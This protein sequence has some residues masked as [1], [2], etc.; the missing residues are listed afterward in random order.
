MAEIDELKERT[1]AS[2]AKFKERANELREDLSDAR[3][4]TKVQMKAMIQRLDE[5]YERATDRFKDL[6]SSS[7][8]TKAD[9]QEL[10]DEIVDDLQSMLKTIRRRIR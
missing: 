6:K 10:H 2:L 7:A 9:Y 4:A 3:A 1:E 5:K 8:T